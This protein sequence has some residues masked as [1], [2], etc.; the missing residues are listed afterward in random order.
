MSQFDTESSAN[1][2]YRG[3]VTSKMLTYGF[4]VKLYKCLNNVE[5]TML[6]SY[7]QNIKEEQERK[8]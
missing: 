8:E 4:T 1:V 7:I 5:K 3:K 2:A 6:L